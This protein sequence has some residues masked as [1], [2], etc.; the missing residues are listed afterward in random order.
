ML[1]PVTARLLHFTATINYETV[2]LQNYYEAGEREMEIGQ[3]KM[4]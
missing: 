2:G 4:P 3:I 1:S